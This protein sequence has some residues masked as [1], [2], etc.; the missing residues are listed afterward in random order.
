LTF[1]RV[2]SCNPMFFH[3]SPLCL[4]PS[5]F[6]PCPPAACKASDACSNYTIPSSL[7]KPPL[8]L[9]SLPP[10]CCLALAC[11]ISKHDVVF[12]SKASQHP[13]TAVQGDPSLYPCMPHTFA[14]LPHMCTFLFP[15]H[16][17]LRASMR[18]SASMRAPSTA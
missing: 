3:F 12:K 8:C 5:C 1:M 7:S 6:P 13:K 14:S 16:S 10:R 2:F 15:A 11:S 9:S 17:F 4:S 18:A